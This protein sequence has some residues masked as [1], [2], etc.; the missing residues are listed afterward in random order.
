MHLPGPMFLVR[1]LRLF[2]RAHI[3]WELGS[4]YHVQAHVF[5]ICFFIEKFFGFIIKKNLR[6][7]LYISTQKKVWSSV[8]HVLQDQGQMS[9]LSDVQ[10]RILDG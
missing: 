3:F 6:S 5:E 7:I 2:T 4:D 1:G 10:A 8:P 9:I